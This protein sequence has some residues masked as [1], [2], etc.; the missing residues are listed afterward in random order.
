MFWSLEVFSSRSIVMRLPSHAMQVV[1]GVTRWGLFLMRGSPP[2]FS[3]GSIAYGKAVTAVEGRDKNSVSFLME[4][5]LFRTKACRLKSSVEGAGLELVQV[6]I[7]YR[8][9]H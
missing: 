7:T 1:Q 8:V 5:C 2:I 9:K 4:R 6:M 3:F